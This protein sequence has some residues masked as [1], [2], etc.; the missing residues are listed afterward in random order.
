MIVL[1]RIDQKH[2]LKLKS[3]SEGLSLVS[4]EIVSLGIE[5]VPTEGAL[6][7]VISENVYSDVTISSSHTVTMDGYTINSYE[8]IISSLDTP[9]ILQIIHKILSEG[10]K[11]LKS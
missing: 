7:R 10:I 5:V 1:Y 2:I 9:V 4:S 6:G 11:S 3:I 8:I